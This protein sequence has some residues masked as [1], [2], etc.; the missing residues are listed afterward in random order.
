MSLSGS[1]INQMQYLL[2]KAKNSSL[3][4]QEQIQLRNLITHEQ[5]SA[6]N[7]SLDDLIKL[8]LIFV[9]IYILAKAFEDK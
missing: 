9:G 6:Q 2:G 4:N 7:S 3:T 8:G 1:E 5:P